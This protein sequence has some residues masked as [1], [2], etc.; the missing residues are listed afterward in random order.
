LGLIDHRTFY[1]PF[2]QTIRLKATFIERHCALCRA[3]ELPYTTRLAAEM[4]ASFA[5]DKQDKFRHVWRGAHLEI[6]EA[7]VFTNVVKGYL[8]FHL[9]EGPATPLFGMDFGKG[10]A[11]PNAAVKLYLVPPA[12]QPGYYRGCDKKPIIFVAAEAVERSV[13]N[14]ELYKLANAVGARDNQ[15]LCDSAEPMMILALQASGVPN[16]APAMKGAGS[17][18]AGIT[19]L[20]SCIIMISP[21]CP[22]A[23]AE[24]KGPRWAT[25]PRTGKVK[26]PLVTVG[27]DHVVDASR[28]ALS[29]T[30]LAEVEASGVALV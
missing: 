14:H 17:I 26:R 22:E 4:R 15:M 5:R 9:L 8:N 29:E 19:K 25:D 3:L 24:F 7:T 10:G 20:Q 23:Y 11:D 16:A 2:D 1:A 27:S 18:L 12:I 30:E 28:Y 6:T 21:E 13:P